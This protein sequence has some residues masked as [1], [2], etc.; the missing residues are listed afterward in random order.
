VYDNILHQQVAYP[1]YISQDA[2]SLLQGVS[3]SNHLPLNTVIPQLLTRDPEKR[4]GSGP[5]GSMD[6]K[7]HP[8]F[9]S[10]D[11]EKLERKEIT[12]PFVPKVA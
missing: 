6:I 1:P 5:D 10:I 8:F 12:P 9:S 4:L 2:K 7:N 11:W 3:H